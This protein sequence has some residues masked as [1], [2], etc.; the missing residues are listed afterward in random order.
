MPS[1]AVNK[2]EL[3][4]AWITRKLETAYSG[5]VVIPTIRC[6]MPLENYRVY[7]ARYHTNSNQNLA[8]ESV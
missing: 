2:A 4:A 5:A 7:Y 6:N 1:T 3:A 8:H